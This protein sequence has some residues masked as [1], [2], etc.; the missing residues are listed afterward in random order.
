[1]SRGMNRNKHIINPLKGST[2]RSWFFEQQ[3]YDTTGIARAIKSADGSGNVPKI[4]VSFSPTFFSIVVAKRL[5]IVIV[6]VNTIVNPVLLW[7]TQN[8]ICNI[9]EKNKLAFSTPLTALNQDNNSS[10]DTSPEDV[11]T[12]E[13]LNF[14]ENK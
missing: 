7:L 6:I 12:S 8:C 1:M 10:D 3:V 14:S 2:D 5:L 13:E 11:N 4:I 9:F